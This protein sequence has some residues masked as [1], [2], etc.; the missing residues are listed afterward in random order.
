MARLVNTLAFLGLLAF[1]AVEANPTATFWRLPSSTGLIIG[2][3]ELLWLTRFTVIAQFTSNQH[4]NIAVNMEYA[5]LYLLAW[6]L[7]PATILWATF[8]ASIQQVLVFSVLSAL[9]RHRHGVPIIR[10]I[11]HAFG[12]QMDRLR[13]PVTRQ[14]FL[15]NLL[16]L[17]RQMITVIIV[18]TLF[19]RWPAL[20]LHFHPH[21]PLWTPNQTIS[22]LG[23]IMV[24]TLLL[25]AFDF[26]TLSW[27]FS[28]PI[29]FKFFRQ[30]FF[31]YT[32]LLNVLSEWLLWIIGVPFVLL[33]GT[34][35]FIAWFVLIILTSS[36]LRNH[37]TRQ[38]YEQ[39]LRLEKE[40][41]RTDFLTRL[42]VRRSVEE[43]VQSLQ[44]HHIPTIVGMLDADWFKKVNDSYGHDVGDQV[45]KHLAQYWQTHC[46]KNGHPYPDM[47]ARWG[48]EEFAL[49][50]PRM[51]LATARSRLH[52]LNENL[53]GQPLLTDPVLFITCSIGL[54]LWNPEDEDF[55]TAMK[56]ADQA[57]Y[58]AKQGGRNRV[59]VLPPPDSPTPGT[60]E[61]ASPAWPSAA[62]TSR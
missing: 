46:R 5:P 15:R 54:T 34:G 52:H 61:S 59:C 55:D 8:I 56:R 4:G 43:Y 2:L 31:W 13:E 33:A 29:W 3:G 32:T 53:A 40:A 22:C 16:T 10:T 58:Q 11:A 24:V 48:G 45:L 9:V 25:T 44:E 42:P 36:L 57:V 1:I 6:F 62:M 47:V 27:A 14:R 38:Q 21:V 51:D 49:I 30:S 12:H 19:H 23:A 7:H 60:S 39:R 35:G 28:M 37:L 17:S 41:A 18:L 50:L 26:W 20:A